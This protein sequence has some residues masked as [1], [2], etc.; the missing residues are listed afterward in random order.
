MAKKTKKYYW[1]NDEG[2]KISYS[3]KGVIN[4]AIEF[5]EADKEENPEGYE[6]VDCNAYNIDDAVDYLYTY[7]LYVEE[8]ED[9]IE[10]FPLDK[11]GDNIKLF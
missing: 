4:W 11:N 7:E 8:E 1:I 6:D 2:K 9:V 3:E 5:C 10:I